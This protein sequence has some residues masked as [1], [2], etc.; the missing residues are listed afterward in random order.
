[1][2]AVAASALLA[3]MIVGPWSSGTAQAAPFNFRHLNKIQQRL[4]S[5]ALAR[6]SGSARPGRLQPNAQPGGGDDEGPG[7]DG[8]PNT[9]PAASRRAGSGHRE[10]LRPDRPHRQLGQPRVERQGQ[11]ELPEPDRHRLQGR[12][13][14]QN[15][16]SIAINPFNR[17]SS[18]PATTTTGAATAT[19][20]RLQHRRRASWNDSTVPKGFTRGDAVRRG[21]R[22][23]GRPAA[24]RRS[25]GTPGQR[26]PVVPGVQPRARRRRRT[27]TCPAPSSCSARPAT[28]ARRGTSPAARPSDLRHRRQRHARSRTSN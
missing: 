22:S 7:A 9:P 23:T 27:R 26:L 16:T 13:Q 4:V 6:L 17:S 10:Q 19:A 18:S 21:P 2:P 3:G 11:P 20:A 12:G 14:A 24:T 28:A 1:M 15:E 8:L 25:R 5:G